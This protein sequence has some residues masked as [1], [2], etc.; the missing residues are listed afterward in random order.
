[1]IDIRKMSR[2]ILISSSSL[3]ILFEFNKVVVALLEQGKSKEAIHQFLRGLTKAC[4]GEDDTQPNQAYSGED[5]ISVL[6]PIDD[7]VLQ[8]TTL[9]SV[10]I[11]DDD[12]HSNF[13]APFDQALTYVDSLLPFETEPSVDLSLVTSVYLFNIGLAFHR[14]GMAT[15][16]SSL[17][18]NALKFY[19]LAQESTLDLNPRRN[20]QDFELVLFAIHNNMG[21][22]YTRYFDRENASICY[23][24]IVDLAPGMSRTLAGNEAFLALLYNL[25][26]YQQMFQFAPAA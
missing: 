16:L 2:T 26:S 20:S 14:Q 6:I 10:E 5:Q 13:F 12:S 24:S 1:M 7:N 18:Q 23:K 19:R 15:G 17:F 4:S 3:R 11:S 9:P 8:A 25:I 22:I 21:N